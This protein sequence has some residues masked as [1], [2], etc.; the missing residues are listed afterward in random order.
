MKIR[1]KAT[2]KGLRSP[3]PFVPELFWLLHHEVLLEFAYEPVEL[4]ISFI[5]KVKPYNEIPTRLKWLRRVKH[6]EKLPMAVYAAWLA[7][8]PACQKQYSAV[9]HNQSIY[10]AYVRTKTML[11]RA[12]R[13]HQVGISRR[14]RIECP[15]CPWDPRKKTLK[16]PKAKRTH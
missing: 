1:K 11:D 9:D 16:F 15:G 14:H 13:E 12:L 7:F 8:A 4:R 3:K 10:L 2:K 6:P 5:K